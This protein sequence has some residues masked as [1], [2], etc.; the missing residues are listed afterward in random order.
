MSILIDELIR[1][2]TGHT[3]NTYITSNTIQF[4]DKDQNRY[5]AKTL[6]INSFKEKLKRVYDAFRILKGTSIAVHYKE[7]ENV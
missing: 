4:S 6:K 1:K 2:E 7:D 5:L 3:V